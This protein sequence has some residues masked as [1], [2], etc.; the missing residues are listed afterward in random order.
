MYMDE[1]TT[2]YYRGINDNYWNNRGFSPYDPNLVSTSQGYRAEMSSTPIHDGFGGSSNSS[3]YRFGEIDQNSSYS[4]R[5]GEYRP[6]RIAN[7]SYY[8]H[9]PVAPT[10]Y[11]IDVT[12]P[13]LRVFDE[14]GEYRGP[15]TFPGQ[16]F[17]HNTEHA[18]HTVRHR[19][20]TWSYIERTVKPPVDPSKIQLDIPRSGSRFK[21]VINRILDCADNL[22][23]TAVK[24]GIER[25]RLDNIANRIRNERHNAKYDFKAYKRANRH[26]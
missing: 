24:K 26:F 15:A 5:L 3:V 6:V 8:I 20:P 22:E 19:E 12:N 17:D 23:R 14:N 1:Y 25:E 16:G 18:T 2:P 7:P 21:R 10:F 11:P 9:E 13:E 4:P